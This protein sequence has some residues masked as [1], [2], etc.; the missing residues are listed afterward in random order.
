MEGEKE[1]GGLDAGKGISAANSMLR[2]PR[3]GHGWGACQGAAR[4][5][6]GRGGSTTGRG[7]GEAEA[8]DGLI[9]AV[10]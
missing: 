5:G 1:E 9:E 3:H 7:E 8:E 4:R 6:L 10:V 2:V